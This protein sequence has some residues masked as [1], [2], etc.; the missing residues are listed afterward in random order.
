[1][2]NLLNQINKIVNLRKLF[3]ILFI[4]LWAVLFALTIVKLLFNFWYPIII[5]NEPFMT[6]C[7][8]VD[9]HEPIKFIIGMLFYI[10][11]LNI[12]YLT[13]T[14]RFKYNSIKELSIINIIIL[15]SY[16]IK[17]FSWIGLIPEIA[18]L[19]VLP[20]IYN[21]RHSNRKSKLSLALS[22]LYPIIIYALLNVYQLNILF[23]R[24]LKD[25]LT[26][27]PMVITY[28]M[29]LDYYVFLFI[30][31]IGG[32]L[33]M[34]WIAAG[35]FFSKS[36]TELLAMREVE[37]AKA[38]PDKRYLDQIEKALKVKREKVSTK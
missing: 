13:S 36:E 38:N 15:V 18:V 4:L 1:M 2:K 35:F 32:V 20:I 19:V 25:I 30:L 5:S 11:N 24:G 22:I 28:A 12:T 10:A 29:Q 27:L 26:E 17:Y 31:W 8:F 7:N 14:S 3:L 21:I 33:F 37:L 9:K 6:F 34:G 23:V 16:S